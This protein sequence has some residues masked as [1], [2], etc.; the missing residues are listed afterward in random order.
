MEIL[1]SYI[2]TLRKVLGSSIRTFSNFRAWHYGIL[3]GGSNPNSLCSLLGFQDEEWK[4][5]MLAAGLA[6]L[7]NGD[8]RLVVEMGDYNAYSWR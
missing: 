6:K 7:V 2:F 8:V 5:A 4:D 1:Q 3:L